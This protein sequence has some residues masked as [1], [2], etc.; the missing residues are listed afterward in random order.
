[1]CR[2]SLYLQLLVFFSFF[3]F[4]F[5][6]SISISTSTSTSISTSSRRFKGTEV[7]TQCSS[8]HGSGTQ[9]PLLHLRTRQCGT[10]GSATTM[11]R[12]SWRK[13]SNWAGAS[14]C[15]DTHRDSGWRHCFCSS[16]TWRWWRHTFYA[17]PT[18]ARVLAPI[19]VMDQAYGTQRAGDCGSGE[20][21]KPR[22][23][24]Q[25]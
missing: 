1:M 23:S 13:H 11:T 22:A 9:I 21:S 14:H 20:Q 16:S 10:T 24:C 2:K 19:R 12:V 4:S 25:P 15:E 3:C 8:G 17:P 6:I 18:T 5:S 7:M